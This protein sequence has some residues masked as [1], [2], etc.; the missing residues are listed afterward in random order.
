MIGNTLNKIKIKG[1]GDPFNQYNDVFGPNQN[2]T[3]AFTLYFSTPPLWHNVLRT[4]A[5]VI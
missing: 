5:I 1:V 4:M 3:H 2:E